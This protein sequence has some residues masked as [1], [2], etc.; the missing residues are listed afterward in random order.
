MNTPL[1]FL[2]LENEPKDAE[3]IHGTLTVENITFD[4]FT[5]VN[6]SH[7]V[8]INV[9]DTS[10]LVEK[11]IVRSFRTLLSRRSNLKC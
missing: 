11:P 6:A 8:C 9:N 7:Y 4:V 10:R 5:D 2:H 3:F 1:H